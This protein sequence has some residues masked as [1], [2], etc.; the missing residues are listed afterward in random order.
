M[1]KTQCTFVELENG[2][3]LWMSLAFLHILLAKTRTAP[4]L[5]WLLEDV[6]KANNWKI[7]IVSAHGKAG[8]FACN[9]L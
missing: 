6:C 7:E 3:F 4:G 9:P 8:S 1:V 2:G 5:D